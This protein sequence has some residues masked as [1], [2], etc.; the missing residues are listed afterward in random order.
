MFA[1]AALVFFFKFIY[2][3]HWFLKVAHIPTFIE[4]AWSLILQPNY[5]R[6]FHKARVTTSWLR[7]QFLFS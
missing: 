3:V 7:T 1:K 6:A 4:T 2:Y 5:V